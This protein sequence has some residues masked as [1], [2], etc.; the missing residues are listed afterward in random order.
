MKAGHTPGPWRVHN[1]RGV[2][3]NDAGIQQ[4]ADTGE[5]YWDNIAS[6]GRRADGERVD[7][8]IVQSASEMAE[9]CRANARLI[10]AAPELLEALKATCFQLWNHRAE[11]DVDDTGD[12]KA[13]RLAYDAIAKAEGRK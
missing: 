5:A 8:K 1:H 9:E 10:A 3:I 12:R 11:Y 13:W 2:V 7:P 6:T 4:V